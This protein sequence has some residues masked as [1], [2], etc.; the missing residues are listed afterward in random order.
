MKDHIAWVDFTDKNGITLLETQVRVAEV[1]P[2][3]SKADVF[4]ES[5]VQIYNETIPSKKLTL[6]NLILHHTTNILLIQGNQ[7][8]EW[9]NK[10][11]LLLKAVLKFK[12]SYNTTMASTHSKILNLT[13]KKY[14]METSQVE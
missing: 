9:V 2:S 11:F 6:Y 7:N 10:E 1:I 14:K 5:A 12:S 3:K 4:K 8:L 13:P